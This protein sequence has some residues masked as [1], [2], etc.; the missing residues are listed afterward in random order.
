MDEKNKMM[1]KLLDYRGYWDRILE[2]KTPLQ[3]GTRHEGGMIISLEK[4]KG[5][6]IGAQ[7]RFIDEDNTNPYMTWNEAVKRVTG[8]WRLPTKLE[9]EQI[10]ANIDKINSALDLI[11]GFQLKAY[12]VVNGKNAIQYYWSSDKE[13]PYY[14]WT[15]SFGKGLTFAKHMDE[16]CRVRA[17]KSFK[18]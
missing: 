4:K 7:D 12:E 2:N 16:K 15:M 5:L 8:D 14:P 1:Y 13:S 17:V 6:V 10:Y 9:L 11:S 3:W 18:V